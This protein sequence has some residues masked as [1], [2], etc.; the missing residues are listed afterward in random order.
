MT[1]AE[2][3]AIAALHIGDSAA[4]LVIASNTLAVGGPSSNAGTIEVAN[5]ATLLLSG[6]MNNTGTIAL[7][8]SG[9][10]TRLAISGH[11]ALTGTGTVALGDSPDNAITSDGATAQLWNETTITGSGTIGDANLSLMNLGRIEATGSAAA[12]TIAASGTFT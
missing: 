10:A 2:A 3:N 9:A 1:S 12:L 7:A 8:S 11:V 5:G 4:T 6:P